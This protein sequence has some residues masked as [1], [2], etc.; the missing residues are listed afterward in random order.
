MVCRGRTYSHEVVVLHERSFVPCEETQE[1]KDKGCDAAQHRNQGGRTHRVCIGVVS[2]KVEL[3]ALQC[4]YDCSQ[5]SR[6]MYNVRLEQTVDKG[7]VIHLYHARAHK[8]WN[9]L[10]HASRHSHQGH[11]QSSN[12]AQTC[13][14][15]IDHLPF[16]YRQESSVST[17]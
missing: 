9:V 5:R 7:P 1:R 4:P 11:A 13:S 6:D 16:R 3:K 17:W 10:I 15:K 2:R 14:L 12:N 8:P